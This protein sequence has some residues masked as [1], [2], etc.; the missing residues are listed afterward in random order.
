MFYFE[1]KTVLSSESR[2][3]NLPSIWSSDP[4][5]DRT[6]RYNLSGVWPSMSN[7]HN[8]YVCVF[9]SA[10]LCNNR[11]HWT[12]IG[13]S[14]F[15]VCHLARFFWCFSYNFIALILPYTEYKN[16]CC[17]SF[18][19]FH[20]RNHTVGLFNLHGLNQGQSLLSELCQN[21]LMSLCKATGYCPANLDCLSV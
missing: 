18:N 11:M 16:V 21:M 1:L 14:K 15:P 17:R 8:I 6:G 19:H 2:E 20:L 4:D 13:Y 3:D 9:S 10:S 12:V 7:K 5:Y